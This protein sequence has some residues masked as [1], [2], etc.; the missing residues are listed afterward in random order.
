M[1]ERRRAIPFVPQMEA[2]ECGAACLTMLLKSLGH[3]AELSELR[4]ACGVSRDGV[5]A[6]QLVRVARLY[7]LTTRARRLEP[8]DIAKLEGPGILHW[9]MNHFV[10][11]ERWGKDEVHILDPAIGPRRVPTEEFGK[12]FT[13]IC[14]E[15]AR[16]DA[17]Q[18]K[19]RSRASLTRY[20]R[21]LGAARP[22]LLVVAGGSLV[23]NVLGLTVPLT[24]QLVV[25]RVVLGGQG[26]WLVPIAVASFGL[27]TLLL[28]TSLLRAWLLGRVRAYVDGTM[29]AEIVGHMM[30]LPVR[31]FTQRHTADLVARVDAVRVLR[32]VV[33]ER[34]ASLL[35]DGPLLLTYLGLM[36]AYD[37]RLGLVVAFAGVLYGAVYALFRPRQLAAF[38]ERAV[39][40]VKAAIQL[41]QTIRGAVTLKSSGRERVAHD[42]WLRL[43]VH[44]LNAATTEAGVRV[45]AEAL[46]FAIQ[47]AAPAVVLLWG[48]HR[49]MS[50]A[51]SLG[52][53][54][55]FS[56][57]AA[58]FL[59]PLERALQALLRMQELPFHLARMDDVLTT[60]PEPSGA[61]PAP[62][63]RGDVRFEN[64]TFRYGPTAPP[65]LDAV[66][67][68]VKAG[69]KVALVGP[70]GS[71][72][73]TVARLLLGLYPPE[74]GTIFLDDRSLGELELDSA[75]RQIGAVLQETSLFEGSIRENIA[76]YHPTA[77]L[78]EVISAARA[79]QLHDDIQAMPLGYDTPLSS[80]GGPFS[81]GQRQRLALARAVLHRPAVMVL[82]EAT[83]ALDTVTEAAV[84]SYLSSRMCTRIVIAHR[85]STVRD[86][87]RILVL[88]AGKIVEQGR[89]DE[90]LALEGVYAKLVGKGET[91]PETQAP[92]LPRD[93][94]SAPDVRKLET[95]LDLNAG[96]LA[97]LAG[98]LVRRVLT[99]GT[100]L[101]QQG[102]RGP[103]LYLVESGEL[104]VVIEEPGLAKHRVGTVGAGSL[105]GEVSFLDGSPVSATLVATERTEAIHLPMKELERRRAEGDVVAVRLTLALGRLVAKRLRAKTAEREK[106]GTGGGVE[107]VP[108]AATDGREPK[109]LGVADTALGAS[110]TEGELSR[111]HELGEIRRHRPGEALFRRGDP[112]DTSYLVLGGRIAVVLDDVKT[113]LNTVKPGE[114]LGEVA[115]FDPGPRSA[116]CVAIEPAVTFS[117]DHAKLRS[118]L[119]AG[120]S[121]AAKVLRHLT[122]SL[123]RAFRMSDLRLREA[124]ATGTGETERARRARE[125]AR[126]L[127]SSRDLTLLAEA[128]DG[129]I[130]Y[131]ASDVALSPAA[132][133]AAI[134]RHAGRPVPFT[135]VA[136]ACAEGAGVTPA[137]LD[138]GARSFGLLFRKLTLDAGD[139]RR[140]DVPLILELDGGLHVL[141][142]RFSR[143]RLDLMSP[144]EGR[145]SM[146]LDD[147][148]RRFTGVAYEAK[149]DVPKDEVSLGARVVGVLSRKRRAVFALLLSAVALQIVSLRVPLSLSVLVGRV[150]PIGD[151]GLLRVVAAAVA[152]TVL[153]QLVLAALKSRGLLFLRIQLDRALFDQLFRH[154]LDLRI[155]F[156]E[157][158]SPGALL[159][160]FEAFRIVRDLV[161]NEGLAAALNVPMLL[162][163]LSAMMVIDPGLSALVLVATVVIGGSL[164][165]ALPRLSRLA[166]EELSTATSQ[167]NRLIEALSGVVTLRAV[168]ARDLG[169]RRWLP[170]SMRALRASAAQDSLQSTWFAFADFVRLGTVALFTLVGARRVLAGELPLGAL[171]AFGGVAAG[172]LLAVRDVGSH[173]VAYSRAARR[174]ALLRETFAEPK[175]QSAEL[176][177]QPGRL[178]GAIRLDHVSFSYEEDGADVV[179][180][181]SISIEPGTKVALVGASGSGKSTLGKLLLGFYLPRKGTVLFD[182]RDLSSL[183]LTAVRSQVGVVLQDAQLFTG[184]VR[185]NVAINAPDADIERVIEASKLADIHDTITEL[186]MGY[187]TVVAEG[188]S[189]FS[190]GQRQRLALARALV[191]QPSVLLLDEATSALDNLS[192]ARIEE[193][194]AG[195]SATR[196][197]IAHRLST[198][199]DA[200][201]VIVLD[202]GRVVETGTHE[203]LLRQKGHYH[204]LAQAELG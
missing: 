47:I 191:H 114:L 44:A 165:L 49:V 48:A 127:S 152:T 178:R 43:F 121:M 36:L 94:G 70:S 58:A 156:F 143:G 64:V 86:A 103:G 33:A 17:F 135:A 93:E 14:V 21:M 104:E 98:S 77:S 124:I 200:D 118:L 139:L 147:L 132:C 117:I 167:K 25:D 35:I 170:A 74:A 194:L 11:F 78:E 201:R 7:G 27:L 177:V 82:D 105:V 106:L 55:G 202:R 168:G 63:L 42:R 38:R 171:L 108:S 136:E 23:L 122:H 160:R 130:P 116:G 188:G 96:D 71:G 2:V 45:V 162:F 180:D 61:S 193:S 199:M 149:T 29:G 154:V 204:R 157:S 54:L 133:L 90:L 75:R 34:T 158:R 159:A 189:G 5:S 120:S 84:S 18:K 138:R 67:F 20:A 40:D 110:L 52:E 155:D 140:I 89:H 81:G 196:I 111:L 24:T 192:Q 119:F 37:L 53:L 131:V 190:G 144:V 80:H 68:A 163:S 161:G 186:P 4:E 72:K 65:S 153:T 183:D 6:K 198:V 142:E 185:E 1:V 32:D 173:L 101:V 146:R 164:G 30:S 128:D 172:Y 10:V 19:P 66:S 50:G 56:L 123:V 141:G 181:V 113:H 76:L 166:E 107:A 62:P 129:R 195:M 51:L 100:V 134:L 182:G 99:P 174:V 91:A 151:M 184:S 28:A 46:L 197:V 22:T 179:S 95:L 126:A 102:D 87:D 31:F 176:R 145:S 112:G 83:S 73:S 203:E 150:I 97:V 115:L 57:L 175:E 41:L 3:H 9:E 85:L 109:G 169:L 137:S 16:G 39:K 59:D 88:E 187:E 13:G 8:A 92:E 79:A 125:E 12:S 60:A 26:T 148:A 15:L 69:E